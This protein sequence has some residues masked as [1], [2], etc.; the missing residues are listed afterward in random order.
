MVRK[1]AWSN[2]SWAPSQ[3]AL[4]YRKL[5]RIDIVPAG[6]PHGPCLSKYPRKPRFSTVVYEMN[7]ASGQ[8]E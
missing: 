3:L 1:A 7:L 2:R 5:P 8:L 4:A 6:T